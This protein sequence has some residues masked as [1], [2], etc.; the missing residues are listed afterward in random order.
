MRFIYLLV[1]PRALSLNLYF[2]TLYTAPFSQVIAE[3]YV[4]HHLYADDTQMYISLTG[5][6]ALESLTDLK[7]CVTYVFT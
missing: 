6:E 1:Y 3:H 5:S 4:E 7:S 2:F